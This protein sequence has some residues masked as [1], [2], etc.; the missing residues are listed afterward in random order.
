MMAAVKPSS[1]REHESSATMP[2]EGSKEPNALGPYR[3][4]YVRNVAPLMI[5]HAWDLSRRK[6]N[7]VPPW[8]G[9]DKFVDLYRLT[10]Y[11]LRNANP[12]WGQNFHD[13]HWNAL[14]KR[15]LGVMEAHSSDADSANIESACFEFL[16]P[17]ME[18]R[19]D[20][21]SR[22]NAAEPESPYGCWG[23]DVGES[24]VALHIH[25]ANRPDSPF[26]DMPV[27][28]SDLLR[29]LKDAKSSNPRVEQVRCATWLNNLPIFQSLFPP[30]WLGTKDLVTPIGS[31]A[32]LW[33]QYLDRRGAFHHGHARKFRDS[34]CHPNAC[35]SCHCGY[36][37]AVAHLE[38]SLDQQAVAAS[39]ELFS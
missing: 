32:G 3:E 7:P 37:E 27:L 29:L 34:G 1:S 24:L 22:S 21:D 17:L 28:A 35:F 33:G 12:A 39:E 2:N 26:S 20:Q 13:P 25:N 23:S 10:I 18:P 31:G 9:L 4:D 36:G 19:I 5:W 15:I 16:W 6:A 8:D 30:A 11:N 38:N 14:K